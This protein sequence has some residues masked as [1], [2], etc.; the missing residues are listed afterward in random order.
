MTATGTGNSANPTTPAATYA[1]NFVLGSGGLSMNPTAG[2]HNVGGA[3][4]ISATANTGYHFT[5]WTT[6]RLNYLHRC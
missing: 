4:A 2:P 3:T 5:S 1:V 6:H